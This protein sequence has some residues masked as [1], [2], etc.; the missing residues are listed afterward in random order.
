MR[1]PVS[2]KPFF[3]CSLF[4]SLFFRFSNC[5]HGAKPPLSP[6]FHP[7]SL[8]SDGRSVQ[9]GCTRFSRCCY[10]ILDRYSLLSKGSWAR[11]WAQSPDLGGRARL[12]GYRLS[13]FIFSASF[14]LL[15]GSFFFFPQFF[16]REISSQDRVAPTIANSGDPDGFSSPKF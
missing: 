10:L 5:S 7:H 3:D 2:V 1:R 14:F 11:S 6:P 8:L 13:F 4:S 16:H 15:L 9:V 12:F